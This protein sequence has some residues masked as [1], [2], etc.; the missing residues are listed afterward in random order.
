MKNVM[1]MLSIASE[2]PSLFANET[3]LRRSGAAVLA[4][5][6]TRLLVVADVA[7]DPLVILSDPSDIALDLGAVT[8]TRMMLLVISVHFQ[9]A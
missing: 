2:K 5:G 9:F 1:N 3:T 6:A 4:V 7:N 8:L